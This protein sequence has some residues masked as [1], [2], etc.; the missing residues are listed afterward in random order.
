MKSIIIL[1]FL[2]WLCFILFKFYQ[3]TRIHTLSKWLKEMGWRVY[4]NTNNCGYCIKQV[5]FFGEDLK[6]F[7]VIHCDDK[8]ANCSEKALPMWKN[9][10]GVTKPGAILSID[11]FYNILK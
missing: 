11:A 4:V 9:K 8:Q 3:K 7:D 1:I 5:H 10:D 6:D 2:Y